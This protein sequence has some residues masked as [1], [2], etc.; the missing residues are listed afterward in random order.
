MLRRA[1]IPALGAVCAVP[2]A[3]RADEPS[4]SFG[5]NL[6]I[7][8]GEHTRTG[9]GFDLR[10]G[11]VFVDR[12][13]M[14]C[15]PRTMD[16]AIGAFAQATFF[17]DAPRIALGARGAFPLGKLQHAMALDL[18]VGWS[19]R[20]SG[21]SL[22][23]VEGL[24]LGGL[25]W[26]FGAEA[27]LAAVTPFDGQ[28][29][30]PLIGFGVRYPGPSGEGLDEM[31]DVGR[32]LRVDGHS[33]RAPCVIR[34]DASRLSS[35]PI[36]RRWLDDARS[37]AASVPAFQAIA[38]DLITIGAPRSLVHRARQAARDEV[39][40]ARICADMAAANYG[41]RPS[42]IS[43]TEVRTLRLPMPAAPV[44][45]RA[46]AIV[47]IARESWRDGCLGEGAAAHAA[48]VARDRATDADTRAAQ[49]VIARDEAAHAEL[50]WDV[51][52]ACFAAEPSAREALAAD[53]ADPTQAPIDEPSAAARR[54][55]EALL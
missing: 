45:S 46:E 27:S 10:A 13:T 44:E 23:G 29:T 11:W 18:E 22:P 49:T 7:E 16:A 24:R 25:L 15:R 4:I 1:L 35:D 26:F 20:G 40:H 48:R 17:P 32:P 31:C 3:A 14:T 30:T 54:R 28:P 51:L 52:A 8:L 2:A 36:A 47:R 42:R 6:V 5:L 9:I 38:R 34:G 33:M 41:T 50:A 12:E 39:R 21:T 55:L 43:R 53:L 37:E 19:Y